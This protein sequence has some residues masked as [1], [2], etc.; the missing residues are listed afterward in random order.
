MMNINEVPDDFLQPILA[1]YCEARLPQADMVTSLL[2]DHDIHTGL[3]TLQRVLQYFKLTNTPLPMTSEQKDRAYPLLRQYYTLGKTRFEAMCAINDTYDI[4][5]NMYNIRTMSKEM[6][7][8]WRRDDIQQGHVTVDQV[9]DILL[10]AIEG[11]DRHAGYRCMQQNLAVNN[12]I[13]INRDIAYQLMRIIDPEGVELRRRGCLKRRIFH[14]PGPNHLWSS[15]GHD[16]LKPYDICIYGFIDAWSRKVLS[17]RVGRSNNN[18]RVVGL[19]FLELVLAL[20]GFPSRTSTDHG[21]ETGNMATFQALMA[22]IY[23]GEPLEEALKH[24]HYTSSPHN[25]KIESLWLQLMRA[26]NT[27]LRDEIQLAIDKGIYNKED[28]L[29]KAL[30]LHLWIPLV[31]RVMNSFIDR[32]NTYRTRKNQNSHLPTSVAPDTCFYLPQN[33]G[34]TQGL[35]P[36]PREDIQRMIEEQYPDRESL[37][38]V[39]PSQF[40]QEVSTLIQ[41]LGVQEDKIT[42]NNVWTV[43]QRVLPLLRLIEEHLDLDE[44]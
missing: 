12:Q 7:L 18:P 5:I 36:V 19:Y 27:T 31:Q 10:E 29:Q 2:S 37:L 24:H 44:L 34:G 17:V 23:C 4:P 42:L 22:H 8:N 1:G 40:S 33:Y 16:K 20:G 28:P 38:Q 13:R 9:V 15:D 26:K 14:V 43:F 11:E 32:K 39:S 3:R 21:T 30:F 35:I 6:G 41:R 25:Q